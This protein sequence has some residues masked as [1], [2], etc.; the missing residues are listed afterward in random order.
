MLIE[1]SINSTRV[2][3]RV[4]AADEVERLLVDRFAAFLQQRAEAFAVL[5]R[6]P[7]PG[8]DVSFLI[9]AAHVEA[10]GKARLVDFVVGFMEGARQF[11]RTGARGGWG[12]GWGASD[13]AGERAREEMMVTSSSTMRGTICEGRARPA[14]PQTASP[15][16]PPPLRAP[17]TSRAMHPTRLAVAP[18]DTP[19]CG[20]THPPTHPPTDPRPHSARAP[21]TLTA[22][23]L[24]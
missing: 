8:Y 4:K 1:P 10:L 3:L 14:A 19:R 17:L 13:P 7:L 22:K 15:T 5:R 11:G 12:R 20:T 21:Q 18:P 6:A 2:S 9:T 23:F 24:R 16:A